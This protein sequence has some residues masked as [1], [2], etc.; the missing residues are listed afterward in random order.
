MACGCIKGTI[1]APNKISRSNATKKNLVSEK[2]RFFWEGAM[3]DTSV[4]WADTVTVAWSVGHW[5]GHR[6][7]PVLRYDR[8]MM[9]SFW[10]SKADA[11][12]FAGSVQVVFRSKWERGWETA[13]R[14]A[15]RW[16]RQKETQ[17]YGLARA[18]HFFCRDIMSMKRLTEEHMYLNHAICNAYAACSSV[19]QSSPDLATDQTLRLHCAACR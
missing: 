2:N 11:R 10:L 1:F 17:G 12:T 19:G 9:R 4:S 15:D 13:K 7:I 18:K 3:R 8:S 14:A 5:P 16:E 6:S